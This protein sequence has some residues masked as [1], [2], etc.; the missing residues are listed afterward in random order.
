MYK[1]RSK[2]VSCNPVN[3]VYCRE[4]TDSQSCIKQIL[5]ARLNAAKSLYSKNLLAH[6]GCVNAI[7]FSIGGELLAS[8]NNKVLCFT[9]NLQVINKLLQSRS[10][11]F[12]LLI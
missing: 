6:F 3:Y 5:T 12:I 10:V 9:I 8:G 2:T 1:P 4:Y 11:L 7:E